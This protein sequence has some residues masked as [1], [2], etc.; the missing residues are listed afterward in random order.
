MTFNIYM[1]ICI[2]LI[3]M[4]QCLMMVALVFK[5]IRCCCGCQEI[6][7][8]IFIY[9]IYI[10]S[11]GDFQVMLN[12]HIYVCIQK[13][14]RVGYLR[15]GIIYMRTLK[16]AIAQGEIVNGEWMFAIFLN[17]NIQVISS[18]F[19]TNPSARQF[20]QY[21][22]SRNIILYTFLFHIYFLHRAVISMRGEL[23]ITLK[24]YCP[25]RSE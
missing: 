9:K 23:S 6:H 4:L 5:K 21:F 16:C 24:I 10:Y 1:Y 18:T 22:I 25:T 2:H 19:P 14:R 11:P 13:S 7:L 15:Y 8:H 20:I 17:S 12:I 3:I